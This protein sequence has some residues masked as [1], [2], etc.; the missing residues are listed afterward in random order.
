MA[1]VK[2]MAM[3]VGTEARAEIMKK[4]FLRQAMDATAWKENILDHI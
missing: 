1:Q 2:L 4:T 3:V